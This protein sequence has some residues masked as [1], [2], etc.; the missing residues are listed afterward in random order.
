MT[1]LGKTNAKKEVNKSCTLNP[2]L[3]ALL[4]SLLVNVFLFVWPNGLRWGGDFS[5]PDYI[6]F[7]DKF[8]LRQPDHYLEKLANLWGG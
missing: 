3:V 4:L 5:N 1:R 2:V 7:D 8:N 6:H